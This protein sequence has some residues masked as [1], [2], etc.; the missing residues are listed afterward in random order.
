VAARGDPEQNERH[1]LEARLEFATGTSLTS[2]SYIS[3]IVFD[4]LTKKFIFTAA[5]GFSRSLQL[6]ACS[7]ELTSHW[8]TLFA[9]S[10]GIID[11][12]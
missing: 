5:I 2:S 3:F 6:I 10:N 8:K 12:Y 11:Q 4:L 1:Q 7:I 9:I